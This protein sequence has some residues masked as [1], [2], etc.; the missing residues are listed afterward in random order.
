MTRRIPVRAA[1]A[2][3]SWNA[4]FTHFPKAVN[5]ALLRGIPYCLGGGI[6]R[7]RWRKLYRSRARAS[8]WVN[9]GRSRW[10]GFLVCRRAALD[11]R[12]ILSRWKAHSLALSMAP[13]ARSGAGT[14]GGHMGASTIE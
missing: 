8:R 10:H 1:G 13:A 6:D 3:K 7:S 12:S 14:P 11:R 5:D 2:E 9:G 4:A